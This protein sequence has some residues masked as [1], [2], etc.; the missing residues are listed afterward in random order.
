MSKDDGLPTELREEPANASETNT[1]HAL[2]HEPI[3]DNKDLFAQAVALGSS[4]LSNS[5][6]R[7][8]GFGLAAETECKA[9]DSLV[10]N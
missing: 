4:G 8:L 2:V 5:R 3:A 6:V 10:K 9:A 1:P 7:G